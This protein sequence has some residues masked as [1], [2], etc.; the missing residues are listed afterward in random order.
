MKIG[1]AL[2]NWRDRL[3]LQQQVAAITALLCMVLVLSC[4]A[5]A[6]NIAG[7]QAAARVETSILGTANSMAGRLETYMD[8]RF[9]DIHDLASLSALGASWNTDASTV[10]ATLNHLQTSV[11]DF[12]WIGF[13][14]TTGNVIAATKGMLENISVT[15][16][17]WFGAGLV[18]TTV[19]DV[20]DA[21]S[22]A[23]LLEPTAS[24]EPHRF[25]DIAVPVKGPSGATEGVLAANLDWDWSARIRDYMLSLSSSSRQNSIWILRSD[26]R[27]L[28]GPQFGSKLLPDE[29]IAKA[30]NGQQPVFV[31]PQGEQTLTAVVSASTGILADLGW[32]V[33]V[34]RPMGIAM[35]E[36]H[37]IALTIVGVGLLLSLIGTA[38]AYFLAARLTLPLAQ[39]TEQV[40]QLGRDPTVTTISRRGGSSDVRHLSS[41]VRSLLHRAGS[42]E[43]AKEEAER[44]SSTMQ[45]R[46]DERT[47]A[48]GEHISTLQQQAD[49]DSLTHLLNRRAFLVIASDAMNYFRRYN[50]DICVLVI[51]IDFFKRVN[52]T[53]GHGAGDDVIQFVGNTIQNAVRTTD[54]VARFGG[55]EFVVLL[56]ETDLGN[57][58]LLAE[59]IREQI[60]GDVVEV[61][62]DRTVHVT[63]SVGV[64]L[65]RH[66]DRDIADVIERADRALYVAKTTGRNRVHADTE[67]TMS[68][69][70]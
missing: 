28:L 6:A 16:R 36:A 70:A 1:I 38:A 61:R 4:A 27:M 42:A 19:Q 45:E 11:P 29:I 26:G 8:E 41:V 43:F 55:E 49:T 56:R 25:V 2:E 67:T 39:L 32:I 37:Q 40:D 47:R 57:A 59:R 22:L 44:V 54:K 15:D 64:A 14:S 63:A 50:R 48:M 69:A 52:D 13:V 33:V 18:E 58:L 3:S 17:S 35:A 20:S 51:D 7:E 24:G 5:L 68:E 9:R 10:H 23:A 53:F 46:F 66:K 21:T 12:A 30:R 60:C 34:R 65:A 31:D 62:N